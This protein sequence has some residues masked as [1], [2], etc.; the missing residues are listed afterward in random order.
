VSAPRLYDV[1]DDSWAEV[2]AVEPVTVTPAPPQSLEGARLHVARTLR[3]SW[4][5]VTDLEVPRGAVGEA[6]V[7]LR[8]G[9]SLLASGHG[10]GG[11]L[12]LRPDGTVRFL[13]V[14]VNDDFAPVFAA[15]HED[16]VRHGDRGTPAD[17]ARAM[18]A[19][20]RDLLTALRATYHPA[21]PSPP[22]WAQ[23]P[24]DQRELGGAPAEVMAKLETRDMVLRLPDGWGGAAVEIC[25]KISVGWGTCIKPFDGRVEDHLTV[26]VEPGR[27]L[28]LW[29]AEYP[30]GF[31][32]RHQLALTVTPERLQQGAITIYGAP[33][34]GSAEDAWSL[35]A[36]EALLRT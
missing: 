12:A 30:R 11:L 33:G 22:P 15:W 36:R 19:G 14:C 8:D 6:D 26:Y 5:A 13:G 32:G 21:R 16:R 29:L 25:P 23:V 18:A 31:Y 24:P 10:V 9:A 4:T 1:F 28:Q 35:V 20:D 7:E 34:V 17:L 27:P 3:G 2:S